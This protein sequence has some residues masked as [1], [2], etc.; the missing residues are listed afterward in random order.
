MKTWEKNSPTF[1]PSRS[2]NNFIT[3]FF[4]QIQIL[5][6]N[7]PMPHTT[8]QAVT[9]PSLWEAHKAEK[10]QMTVKE[11]NRSALVQAA[12]RSYNKLGI[13]FLKRSLSVA[14]W[15]IWHYRIALSQQP[16]TEWKYCKAILMSS[17]LWLIHILSHWTP[18]EGRRPWTFS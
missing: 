12:C 9:A 11:W 17:V 14:V 18:K 13:S 5:Q 7:S 10:A 1:F 3:F 2:V 6:R 15:L 4:P 8:Y 16:N